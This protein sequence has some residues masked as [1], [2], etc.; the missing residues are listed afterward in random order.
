M[1]SSWVQPTAACI[2][3][4]GAILG[5]HMFH[6]KGL[7]QP[8]FSLISEVAG[9]PKSR[10]HPRDSDTWR[11]QGLPI[12]CQKGKLWASSLSDG[13]RILW[14]QMLPDSTPGSSVLLKRKAGHHT[15][16]MVVLPPSRKV[17]QRARMLQHNRP[18]RKWHAPQWRCTDTVR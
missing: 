9:S 11:T 5:L 10:F 7:H 2:G 1:R 13:P 17:S 15:T 8:L 12:N 3:H 6:S 14:W 18:W 4:Q 16:R